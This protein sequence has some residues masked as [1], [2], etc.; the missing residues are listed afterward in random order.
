MRQPLLALLA[1]LFLVTLLPVPQA[2]LAESVPPPITRAGAIAVLV[3][4]DP[5]LKARAEWYD[6]HMPPMT[7]FYDVEQ[8]Q[9]YAPYLEAAFEAGIIIG[10]ETN[11]EFR[12]G[13]L[14]KSEEAIAYATRAKAYKDPSAAGGVVLAE[15]AMWY[16]QTIALA[17]AY[18]IALPAEIRL[19]EA[20]TRDELHAMYASAGIPGTSQVALSVRIAPPTPVIAELSAP[21]RQ[22]ARPTTSRPPSQPAS[23]P[24]TPPPAAP[25]T[26]PPVATP[27]GSELPQYASSKYFAVTIPAAGITDLT[28]T[29]PSNAATSEGLL[30][31]L[32]AGVGH[33]FSY[34]GKGGKILIYGHSSSYPWDVS[35]FTKIFRQIN[36]LNPGD[37]IYV[38]HDGTMYVY[39]V[40]HESVVPATDTSAYRGTGEELILY[41]C[42]PPDDIKQRYLIHATP[43]QTI[44]LK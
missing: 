15:D 18:G 28:I 33:L 20:V 34:P 30:A 39:Q 35:A 21:I 23:R 41:T 25:V 9:W 43:V 3:E 38:T 11:R 1:A 19:G 26:P 22:P 37:M 42:W 10:I 17:R 6:A 40:T 36:K 12:P 5:V 13:D 16:D 2:A 8:T 4:A 27:A 7:L 29:H 14:L 44:A 31:P 24:A 32:Q